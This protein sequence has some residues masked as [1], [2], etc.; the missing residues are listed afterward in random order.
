MNDYRIAM[1]DKRKRS[2]KT[3]FYGILGIDQLERQ[4]E[5]RNDIEKMTEA[6]VPDK[7]NKNFYA[8]V[9]SIKSKYNLDDRAFGLDNALFNTKY[10]FD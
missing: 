5:I 8:Q 4:E 9:K 6:V 3:K 2:I 7:E 10:E 1:R